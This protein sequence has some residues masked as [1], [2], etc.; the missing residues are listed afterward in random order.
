MTLGLKDAIS[1]HAHEF[2]AAGIFGMAT[3]DVL[4]VL[5]NTLP[6]RGQVSTAPEARVSALLVKFVSSVPADEADNDGLL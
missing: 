2:D 6:S 4:C 3:K 1:V 5:E